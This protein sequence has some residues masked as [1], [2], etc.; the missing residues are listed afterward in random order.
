MGRSGLRKAKVSEESKRIDSAQRHIK[1]KSAG[2]QQMEHGLRASV[3][4]SH[5]QKRR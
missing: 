5:R 3:R 1:A 4:Q 2:K